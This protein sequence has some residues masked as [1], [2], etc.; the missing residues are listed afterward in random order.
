MFAAV[1]MHRR[2]SSRWSVNW[3]TENCLHLGEE[4]TFYDTKVHANLHTIAFYRAENGVKQ[5]TSS[6]YSKFGVSNFCLLLNISLYLIQFHLLVISLSLTKKK[7]Y[8]L[9][10]FWVTEN[11]NNSLN[12]SLCKSC[13]PLIFWEKASLWTQKFSK[14]RIKFW[15]LLLTEM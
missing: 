3:F 15:M 10:C 14:T 11:E 6:I 5:A 1:F 13:L 9:Q 2:W 8:L 12:F 7:V 4:L